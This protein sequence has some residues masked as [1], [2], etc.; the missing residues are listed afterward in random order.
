MKKIISAVFVACTFLGVGWYLLLTTPKKSFKENAQVVFDFEEYCDEGDYLSNAFSLM[1]IEQE[2]ELA[3]IMACPEDPLDDPIKLG[4]LAIEPNQSLHEIFKPHNISNQEIFAL[5]A[6]LN[7]HIRARDIAVGDYYKFTLQKVSGVN[8]IE[9]FEIRKPDPNRLPISYVAKRVNNAK[10][11]FVI[12]LSSP[13]ISEKTA[14]FEITV[15]DTLFASF[16]GLPF[17]HE[18]MQ[19]VMQVLAWRMRMPEQVAKNDKIKILVKQN[20]ADKNFLSYGDIE[21]IIYEQSHQVIKAFYFT[22]QDKKIAGY[23]D[24]TGMSLEKELMSSPTRVTVA[25]SNQRLRFHPVYKSRMRHNGTD[26]RGAIGTDFYAIGDG[27]IIEKRFDNNVGNMMR[28][29]HKYGVHSEYFHADSLVS[30]LEVGQ[31]VKRGQKI[32]EIGRTGRLCTGPHLHLGLYKLKGEKRQYIELSSLRNI[33]TD[34]PK[35][36][37]KYLSEFGL[38]T[39][40]ALAQMRPTQAP[41][42]IA[43]KF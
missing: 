6:A 1:S 39:Q 21:A 20:F 18:L 22:S 29:R 9:S 7:P 42:P 43:N 28:I 41:M 38:C 30:S 34:L 16:S 10:P 36:H 14:L 12:T 19:R 37:G 25:T 35:L 24:E 31:H 15:K 40:K 33:L 2:E 26:F 23:Y 17:G 5:S 8:V 32:G 3:E 13:K 4:F 11:S 27:E